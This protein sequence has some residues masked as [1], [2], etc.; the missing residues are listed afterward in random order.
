MSNNQDVIIERVKE[1]DMSQT[2]S[3]ITPSRSCRAI[4]GLLIGL[5]FGGLSLGSVNMERDALTDASTRLSVSQALA[6]SAVPPPPMIIPNNLASPED[7]NLS[8]AEAKERAL[9]Y[10]AEAT[11]AYKQ[12]NYNAALRALQRAYLISQESS[13]IANIGLVFREMNR[14]EDAILALEYFLKTS[15]PPDKERAAR[16]ATTRG[17]RC[18]QDCKERVALHRGGGGRGQNPAG[19][20]RERCESDRPNVR[21]DTL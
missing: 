6:E 11:Q 12:G 10:K 19:D 21:E 18:N 17:A 5:T 4:R 7:Q 20:C 2:T 15:P 14:Y 8:P 1:S 3:N 16:Q 9:R 13:Y